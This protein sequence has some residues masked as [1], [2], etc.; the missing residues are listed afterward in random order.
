MQKE[1]R[2]GHAVATRRAEG[3]DRD[4]VALVGKEMRGLG[5]PR[6]LDDSDHETRMLWFFNPE[7]TGLRRID[8]DNWSLVL[9][10]VEFPTEIF[11]SDLCV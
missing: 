10:T 9:F 1:S 8:L 11:K 3:K 5:I 7:N 2:A 4:F 6:K